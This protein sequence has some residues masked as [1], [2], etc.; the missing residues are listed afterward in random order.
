MSKPLAIAY[1]DSYLNWKLGAGDGSHPTNPVRAKLATEK[2]LE[3][4]GTRAKVI[5]PAPAETLAADKQALTLV[6]SEEHIHAVI[7]NYVSTEW[8]GANKDVA[9]AGFSMFRGTLRL[10]EQVLAGEIQVGFNPQGAKHHA[11]RNRASGFCV[12]NDMAAAAIMLKE[13]G[14]RPLYL[15]WDIHAGDGVHHLLKET[16]IPTLSIHNGAGYPADSELQDPSKRG[17]R[18]TLHNE[19]QSSYNWNVVDRDGDDALEWAMSE[20]FEVIDNYQPDV[21]LLAAGA[22][23]H[24]GVNNLGA[25]NNYSYEGFRKAAN[26]VADLALKHSKGRVIIGGAGGYQ[27]LDHTPEIW[28]QVV[29]EIYNK[30]EGFNQVDTATLAKSA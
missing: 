1:S 22:D 15:D 14:L 19:Q 25:N 24:G 16:D 21:I 4:F 2:L 20:A 27:P 30:V 10:V 8:S 11:Q 3:K 28:F 26:L 29:S 5:D 7:N 13:S 23:G 12:L 6:H 18:H 9:E 17:I